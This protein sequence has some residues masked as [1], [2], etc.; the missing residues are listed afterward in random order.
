MKIVVLAGGTSTERDVS[1]VS[2]TGV[3][4]ALRSL[5][6]QAI[7]LD[8]YTGDA[9]ADPA[10]VFDGAYDTEKAAEM[11]RAMSAYVE[12]EKD[13]DRAF[14][15]PQ[16]L[17][18]CKAADFVFLALHGANGE[19]GRVQ[20]VLDLFKIPYS[21]TDYISSAIAM[22]K[23]RTKQIFRASG[24]PT[25]KGKTVFKGCADAEQLLAEIHPPVIVKPHKKRRMF[26]CL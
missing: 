16:V 3:C 4:E 26:F 14:F 24:I 7:L 22:D 25:P 8:V 20:A 21:G 12:S 5:G 19:D 13:T 10:S 18:I 1:I 6:H 11:M 2:G 15:G 23:T 17:E 9:E